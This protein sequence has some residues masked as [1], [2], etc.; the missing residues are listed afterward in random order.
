MRYMEFKMERQGLVK[1][2]EEISLTESTLPQSYYY[3]ITP[4]V[5]MSRNYAPYERLT[6]RS[7]KVVDIRE[8]PRGYYIVAEFDEEPIKGE[9]TYA[10]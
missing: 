7:G 8:T 2:G 6:A 1:I 9:E 3:T 4:A 10:K 5:A